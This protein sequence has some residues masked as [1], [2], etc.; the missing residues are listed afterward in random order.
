MKLTGKHS[1]FSYPS[2]IFA[3]SVT[4]LLFLIFCNL[5]PF[6]YIDSVKFS[7]NKWQLT[8]NQPDESMIIPDRTIRYAEANPEVPEN[9]PEHTNLI[10]FK[11]QQSSQPELPDNISD[12]PSLP[13]IKGDSVNL[14][15]AESTQFAEKQVPLTSKEIMPKFSISNQKEESVA[16]TKNTQSEGL[17]LNN[18]KITDSQKLINLSTYKNKIDNLNVEENLNTQNLK[19]QKVRPKLSHQILNGPILRNTSGSPRIG[20]LA[21]ESRLSPYGIYLQEMLKS[22]ETQWGELIKNSIR[23][24]QVDKFPNSVTFKFILMR[25]GQIENLEIVD[26]GENHSLP[27]ELCRQSIASRAPFGEW[28]I[29]MVEEFGESDEISITFNYK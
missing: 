11:N 16:S 4:S 22:I 20:K 5:N 26:K 7:S 29:K 15:V 8:W 21:I 2:H 14:K 6:P 24:L 1:S 28:D 18:S 19:L 9:L 17:K 23:Y 3:L 13:K 12:Q 25:N 27:T 10:S